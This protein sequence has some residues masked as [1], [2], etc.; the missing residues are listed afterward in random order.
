MFKQIETTLGIVLFCIFLLLFFVFISSCLFPFPYLSFP[1]LSFSLKSGEKKKL[2]LQD[3]WGINYLNSVNDIERPPADTC[4]C[5]RWK[6]WLLS[7]KE[8]K[9]NN[10]GI[11]FTDSLWLPGLHT[12]CNEKGKKIQETFFRMRVDL[13]RSQDGWGS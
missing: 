2:I 11:T 7:W 6:A 13:K 5:S 3:I 4:D 9:D 10:E 1:T 8:W 12:Q